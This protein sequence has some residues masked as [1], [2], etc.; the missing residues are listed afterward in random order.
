MTIAGKAELGLL[1]VCG[2]VVALLSVAYLYVYLGPVPVPVSALI[3][4]GVNYL[5]LRQA[6]TYTDSIARFL[7]LAAW[8][9]VVLIAIIGPLGNTV[10]LVG[11]RLLLLVVLGFGIPAIT[12]SAERFRSLT[13]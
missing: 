9:V 1:T 10:V 7:P 11:F 13:G 3:G 4:G 12:A 2:A 5:L 6:S 8:T